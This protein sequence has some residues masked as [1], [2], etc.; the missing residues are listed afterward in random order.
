MDIH[1][2]FHLNSYHGLQEKLTEIGSVMNF[3]SGDII[4]REDQYVKGV[5]IVLNGTV[6]VLRKD[7]SGK[8]ILLYYIND[9]ESCVMSFFG[10][11][12]QEKSQV[13]AVAENDV[14]L[15]FIPNDMV[16]K[17]QRENTQ[18]SDYI[19]KLYHMRFEELISV[20][21]TIAFKRM[22]Q[23]IIEFLRNRS[24]VTG[25]KDIQIT[26]HTIAEELGTA[27]AVVSRLIKQMEIDGLVVLGR[28]KVT[29]V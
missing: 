15:I 24:M 7:V 11:M 9:G 14:E 21:N 22:D 8:E 13:I 17:L 16:N 28:N 25:S 3:V 18:W 5:P 27:R 4:L 1:S 10:A 26:H 23:R 12:N 19:L 29:L 20:I 2:N 6:K